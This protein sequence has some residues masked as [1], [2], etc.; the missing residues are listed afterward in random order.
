LGH[1]QARDRIHH[2][3]DIFATVAKVFGDRK[4]DEAGADAQG[5]G[6][7]RS[8]D[9]NDGTAHAFSAQIVF[10]EG[11][12]FAV[13][14]ADQRDDV[15]A[16]GTGTG[17]RPEQRALADSAAPED[18]NT[19]TLPA[20]EEAVDNADSC[21][22]RFFDVSAIHGAGWRGIKRSGFGCNDR[23][24][25]VHRHPKSV[26]NAAEQPRSDI[27]VSLSAARYDAITETEAVGFFKGHQ[28]ETTG[29]ETDHLG[30]NGAVLPGADLAEISHRRRRPPRLHDQADELDHFAFH[31]DRL[32]P[33]QDGGVAT[34]IYIPDRTHEF[35]SSGKA[36]RQPSVDFRQLC[37]D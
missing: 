24:A 14:L 31:A 2:E 18:A 22:E 16:R 17:H 33:I 12:D 20:R 15:Y 26:K 23:G 8:G 3:Q 30:P 27:Y 35:I 1:S 21:R 34:E 4:C 25:A 36:I 5:R 11:P 37:I 29:S 13:S 10:Y 6:P 9:Y 19:L 28:Q 32:D 7:V